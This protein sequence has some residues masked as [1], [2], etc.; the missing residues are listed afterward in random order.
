MQG[1]PATL[2]ASCTSAKSRPRLEPRM[3]RAKPPSGGPV[4]GSIC[5]KEGGPGIPKATPVVQWGVPDQLASQ[6][7]LL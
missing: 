7:Q 5:S 6:R 1:R 2:T 4:R 3:V